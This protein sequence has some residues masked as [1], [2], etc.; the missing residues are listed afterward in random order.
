MVNLSI[1][2]LY[3]IASGSIVTSYKIMK[4]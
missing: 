2:Y 3:F 1:K 4:P